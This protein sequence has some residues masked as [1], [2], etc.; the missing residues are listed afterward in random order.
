MTSR[1]V[2]KQLYNVLWKDP[3]DPGYISTNPNTVNRNHIP[4]VVYLNFGAQYDLIREGHPTLTLF[5]VVNNV[6]NEMPPDGIG[7][8]GGNTTYDLIGRFIRVGARFK[9]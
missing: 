6:T 2:G 1:I 8:H 9:Y 5:G 7:Y 4:A 3:S